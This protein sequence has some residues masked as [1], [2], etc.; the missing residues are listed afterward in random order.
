M[1]RIG[2]SL[3]SGAMGGAGGGQGGLG[4]IIGGAVEEYGPDIL[5]QLGIIS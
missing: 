3:L 5:K 4:D 2:T 1:G